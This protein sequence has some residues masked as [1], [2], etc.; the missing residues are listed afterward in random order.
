MSISQIA[1]L[2][3]LA[4]DRK[5][6]IL[7]RAVKVPVSAVCYFIFSLFSLNINQ[8]AK[9]GLSKKTGGTQ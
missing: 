2:T 3:A 8:T 4:K 9:Y 5:K 7:L 1:S 6:R